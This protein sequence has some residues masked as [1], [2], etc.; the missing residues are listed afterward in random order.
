[1]K[2]TIFEV[3]RD[4]F[5]TKPATDAEIAQ[6]KKDLEREKLKAEIRET[7][8]KHKGGGGLDKFLSV[9]NELFGKT[10]DVKTPRF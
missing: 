1:M 4:H 10:K 8:M 5:K 3:L 2:K 7:K 6:L 9:T